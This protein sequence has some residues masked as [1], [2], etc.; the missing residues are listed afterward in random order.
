RRR[1]TILV[2]DWSSDVCSSD[3]HECHKRGESVLWDAAFDEG[4]RQFSGA[5]SGNSR[6]QSVGN[7]AVKLSSS[8][9][10]N[11]AA[12]ESGNY[13]RLCEIGRASCRERG[14]RSVGGVRV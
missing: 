7:Q 10:R 11:T 14:Q 3:L 1:H 2:S 4:R 6:S 13:L 5:V 12:G 8:L 9:L